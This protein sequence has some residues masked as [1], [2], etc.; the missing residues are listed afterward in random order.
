ME[1][2]TPSSPLP[3]PVASVVSCGIVGEII[4][5]LPLSDK[6]CND[7]LIKSGGITAPFLIKSGGIIA[8]F[9]IKSG[10]KELSEK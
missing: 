1:A 10:G 2:P 9:L 5:F 6:V 3:L 8:P 7:F 4:A